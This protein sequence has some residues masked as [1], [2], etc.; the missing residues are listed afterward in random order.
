MMNSNKSTRFNLIHIEETQSTNNYLQNLL[1]NCKK[2]D[3][4]TTVIASYQNS[5]R[6]QRG[7]TWESE[8]DK[9]LLFSMVVFPTFLNANRQFLLSQIVSLAI[10]EEL[11]QYVNDIAIKW[12]NDIYWKD[13][14]ICGILIENDLMGDN[15]C[16]S[17]IGIGINI[18]QEI[19]NS[20]APNPVSLWQITGKKY[21]LTYILESVINRI[22]QRYQ[23]LHQG[24]EDAIQT[25]YHNAL[26]RKSGFH[27][28]KDKNGDFMAS[29]KRV[30]STGRLVLQ[31]K[32]HNER[33]YLFKE[34]SYI[35]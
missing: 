9:N 29:I 1:C 21:N 13:K 25:D 33:G 32:D 7:N 35:I 4:F 19:F 34:V 3:E 18:N 16:Q 17:I 8:K 5:G 24:D 11:D 20:P 31:D 15:I 2:I 27:H 6:G 12:P 22:Q 30:E 23:S 10:K 14:K 26:Y 28:Y